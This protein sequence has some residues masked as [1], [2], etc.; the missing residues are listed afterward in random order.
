M[1]ELRTMKRSSAMFFQ[2]GTMTYNCWKMY[3]QRTTN[4][5]KYPIDDL[6]LYKSD[7]TA[8]CRVRKVDGG[9]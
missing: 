3:L 4:I 6:L 1:E 5:S 8:E 9:A 7:I 2:C